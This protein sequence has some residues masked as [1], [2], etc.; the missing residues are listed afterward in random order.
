M[1]NEESVVV[2]EGEYIELSHT[3]GEHSFHSIPQLQ[4]Y[5]LTSNIPYVLTCSTF[6]KN[7]VALPSQ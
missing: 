4:H 2:G 3:K 1:Y 6:T 5:E 7:K